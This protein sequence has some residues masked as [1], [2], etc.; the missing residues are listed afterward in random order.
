MTGRG[1][2]AVEAIAA[3][4][5]RLFRDVA[6]EGVRRWKAEAPGRR[7]IGY[8]PVYAPREVIDAAGMLPVGIFGGG[9]QVEIIRGDACFQSYI[10]HIPRSTVEL[11]LS[12]RLDALDG[13]LFPSTCDVIRNL[14]GIWKMLLPEVYVRYVD[15][16]QNFDRAVGGRFFVAE[17]RALAED[18]ARIGGAPVTREALSASIAAYNENR[19]LVERL[20]A[21]RRESPHLAPASEAYLVLRAGCVIP[22]RA[23]D[24]M[25][26]A[27]LDAARVSARPAIDNCRVVVR[28]AFCEAPPL[29]LLKTLERAGCDIVDDDLV[30][31]SR[32][33]RGEVR[34]EGDPFEALAGAFLSRSVPTASLYSGDAEKG[35]DLVETVRAARAEGVIFAAPSF[36][37]PALLDQPMLAAA[38]DREGIPWTAFK[39]AEDTGQ[40][41]T[42]R[43]QAGTFADSIKLWSEP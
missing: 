35:A 17:L 7:A 34:E 18:L 31:V 41:Q 9:D 15:V 28:G 5:E 13:V 36:C 19:R 6:L 23:H 8:M 21:L 37:D 32:W 14:S 16:P 30:L 3:D 4:A 2:A 1:P 22:V 11:A 10:C 27:Y 26:A 20:G 42:I 40:F 29:A 39:Y 43:E 12:G 38:L 33:I 24:R 25:L